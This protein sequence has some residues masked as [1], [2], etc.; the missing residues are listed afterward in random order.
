M[1]AR[2]GDDRL[3]EIQEIFD[4]HFAER[5]RTVLTPE[6]AAAIE[7][8]PLGPYDDPCARVVRAF[9]KAP[10]A[11]KL[12]ILSLGPDGPWAIGEIEIGV[13]GNLIRHPE[14]FES[15]EEAT[16]QIFIRRKDAF[17]ASLPQSPMSSKA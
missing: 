17:L 7:A 9:A 1:T 10:I 16:R 12:V 6:V 13:Q 2:T 3:A 8:R 14:S 15:P 11:G 4:G 5:L